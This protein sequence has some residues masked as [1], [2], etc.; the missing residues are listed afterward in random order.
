MKLT[1]DF[2]YPF[3]L[4]TTNIFREKK[5]TTYKSFLTKAKLISRPLN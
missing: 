3:G 1:E 2:K 4:L 5:T